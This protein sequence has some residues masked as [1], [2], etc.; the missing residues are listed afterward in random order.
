MDGLFGVASL[1]RAIWFGLGG[2]PVVIARYRDINI[3]RAATKAAGF[4]VSKD[5]D[6]AK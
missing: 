4:N 6:F 2:V 5:F 1:T 3:I